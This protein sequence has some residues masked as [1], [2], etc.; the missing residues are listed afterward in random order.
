MRFDPKEKKPKKKDDKKVEKPKQ[1]SDADMD[2]V[3][4]GR[5]ETSDG[6]P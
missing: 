3:A 4:G 6:K 2:K 5:S 1:L